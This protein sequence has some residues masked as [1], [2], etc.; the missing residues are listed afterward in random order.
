MLV[1]LYCCYIKITGAGSFIQKRKEM[2]YSADNPGGWT[3]SRPASDEG[4]WLRLHQ[5]EGIM[6]GMHRGRESG[7]DQGACMRSEERMRYVTT[8][9]V[10]AFLFCN[11]IHLSTR[12]SMRPDP[13]FKASFNQFLKEVLLWSHF[14]SPYFSSKRYKQLSNYHGPS[15]ISWNPRGQTISKP[16]NKQPRYDIGAKNQ[17]HRETGHL[18]Y[19][20]LWPTQF[21]SVNTDSMYLCLKLM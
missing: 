13:I 20:L 16:S 8:R 14:I 1:C 4:V 17:P 11:N 2:V 19:H 10:S 6:M 5:E 21:W 7:Q 18:E 9:L 12:S 15:F 3:S